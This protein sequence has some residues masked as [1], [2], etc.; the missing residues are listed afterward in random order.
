MPFVVRSNAFVLLSAVANKTKSGSG[1]RSSDRRTE[2]GSRVAEYLDKSYTEWFTPH[3][4]EWWA[5][6]PFLP[7]LLGAVEAP[8]D[9]VHRKVHAARG[10][11]AADDALQGQQRRQQRPPCG[12]GRGSQF[13]AEPI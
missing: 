7:P 4:K 9:P 12:M 8:F 5:A 13:E 11:S 6:S 1:N 10:R 3:N 2:S